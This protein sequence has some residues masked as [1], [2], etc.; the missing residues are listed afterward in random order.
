MLHLWGKK[1]E[2]DLSRPFK[3]GG[4][5]LESLSECDSTHI[6]VHIVKTYTFQLVRPVASRPTPRP[7]RRLR[8]PLLRRIFRWREG[9]QE[10]RVLRRA[11]LLLAGACGA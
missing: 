4:G 9:M 2:G 11:G 7:S 5:L 1:A 8:S 6:L 3:T 10:S